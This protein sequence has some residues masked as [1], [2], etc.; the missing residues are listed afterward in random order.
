M[1]FFTQLKQR[2]QF[3]YWFTLLNIFCAV[4]SI[5]FI[6]FTDTI[7]LGINAWIKPLKFF[8]SSAIFSFTMGW[9]MVHLKKQKA[10]TIFSWVVILVLTFENVIIVWQAAN[11]RLSHFNISNG[12]YGLLFSL[13]GVAITIMTL[14]TLYIGLL[15]IWQKEFPLSKQYVLSIRIAILFFVFY[16]FVGG[17]MAANLSHTVGGDMNTSQ[18]LPLLNWSR[19]FGDV[20]VAHFFGMHSL[21]ILPLFGFYIAKSKSTVALVSILYFILV[22]AILLQALNGMPLL[23]M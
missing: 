14:W 6:Q 12:L 10:V 5:V 8:M 23:K 20:R 19:Q 9:I 7:V 21:Q 17:I 16:A 3:L 22:T 1:H 13:M 2:N 15:F 4:L 18:G 11:G